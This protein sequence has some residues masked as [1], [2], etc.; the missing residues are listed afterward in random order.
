MTFVGQPN[1]VTSQVPVNMGIEQWNIRK[2]AWASGSQ[3]VVLRPAVSASL[4]SMLEMQILSP[5]GQTT[6]L[7][8][9]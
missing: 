8:A 6:K 5:Y 3:N 4:G 2:I 9:L 1:I 7:E